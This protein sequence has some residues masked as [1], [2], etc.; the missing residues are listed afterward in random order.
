[1]QKGGSPVSKMQFQ[2]RLS[3]DLRVYISQTH[4]VT[5]QTVEAARRVRGSAKQEARPNACEL[6][7]HSSI[8][9]QHTVAR[10]QLPTDASEC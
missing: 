9:W 5:F 4:T 2:D 7:T 3:P 8:D 6:Q 1:M 10:Q